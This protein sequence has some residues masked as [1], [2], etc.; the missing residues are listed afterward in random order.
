MTPVQI[1][2]VYEAVKYWGPLAGA[3]L[4]VYRSYKKAGQKLTEWAD[5]LLNNHLHHIQEATQATVML[6]RDMKEQ[7]S[8][9]AERV[10]NVRINLESCQVPIHDGR[11]VSVVNMES[12]GMIH[13]ELRNHMK[14]DEEVQDRI[15][16][17]LDEIRAIDDGEEEGCTHG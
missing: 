16:K 2:D 1:N 4:M 11:A 3:F 9:V 13:A 12:L 8:Q 14:N 10:E 7:D 17:S 15:L 6:L 5:K